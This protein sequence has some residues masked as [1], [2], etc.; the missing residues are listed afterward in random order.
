M[1]TLKKKRFAKGDSADPKDPHEAE[2]KRLAKEEILRK[3]EEELAGEE[4]EEKVAVEET[5]E[6]EEHRVTHLHSEETDAPDD[7]KDDR[8][9]SEIEGDDI[10]EDR[11]HE[12]E[13]RHKEHVAG[14]ASSGES[15]ER[16]DEERESDSDKSESEKPRPAIED[17]RPSAPLVVEKKRSFIWTFLLL[18]LVGFLVGIGFLV[19]QEGRKQGQRDALANVTPTPATAPATPTP[20]VAVSLT[21]YIIEVL[22][23]S[24]TSGAAGR[25]QDEL[26]EAGFTVD[27][28]GNADNSDYEE[29]VIRAKNSVPEDYIEDLTAALRREGYAVADEPEELPAT[30]DVDVIVIIGSGSE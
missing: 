8:D 2:K 18:V 9:E 26:T 30:E 23:G 13:E 24:G 14:E 15:E 22:N 27:S 28:V 19:Y 25:A 17:Y 21:D 20:T 6:P 4:R 29:T 10:D 5:P 12:D 16:R 3:V 7:E 1:A 11:E